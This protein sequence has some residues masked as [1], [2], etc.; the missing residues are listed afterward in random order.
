MSSRDFQEILQPSK[1]D[2]VSVEWKI[3]RGSTVKMGDV[4]GIL[5]YKDQRSEMLVEL[6]GEVSEISEKELKAEISGKV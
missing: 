4:I 2:F 5:R 6:L 1:T 3:E